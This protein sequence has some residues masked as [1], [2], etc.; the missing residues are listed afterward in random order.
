MQT[1]CEILCM[2]PFVNACHDQSLISLSTKEPGLK[3][4]V[5]NFYT[6]MIKPF[7]K[8]AEQCF[9]LFVCSNGHQL[10]IRCKCVV[11]YCACDHLWML[12]MIR[13]LSLSAPKNPVWKSP[14]LIS[15]LSCWNLFKTLENLDLPYMLK[16]GFISHES[17]KYV[18][19]RN[20]ILSP[21]VKIMHEVSPT[22]WKLQFLHLKHNFSLFS[23]S[24]CIAFLNYCDNEN[25]LI[26]FSTLVSM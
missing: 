9:C 13:V 10:K 19:N 4:P 24:K 3:I 16:L 8:F 26:F 11:K 18:K 14:F 22:I 17:L 15:S 12:F 21:T 6:T 1:C 5:P 23:K 2:W 7:N 25:N 20:C